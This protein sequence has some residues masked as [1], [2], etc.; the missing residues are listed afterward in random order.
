[1]IEQ[2]VDLE[3][4]I[5]NND[6]DRIEKWMKEQKTGMPLDSVIRRLV[7][8]RVLYGEDRA[9]QIVTSLSQ[10][11]NS[12]HVLSWDQLEQWDLNKLVLVARTINEKV[13]PQFGMI[14]AIEGCGQDECFV[15]QIGQA[16][17]K[18]QRY[19]PGSKEVK[20]IIQYLTE[21]IQNEQLALVNTPNDV[22]FESRVNI[23][24][25][26]SGAGIATKIINALVADFRFV[27]YNQTWLLREWVIPIEKS[28]IRRIHK[29]IVQSGRFYR[30]YASLCGLIW[31]DAPQFGELSI[32]YH[33]RDWADYFQNENEGWQAIKPPPP[34]WNNAK[35]SCYVFNPVDFQIILK[36]GDRLNKSKAD[37]LVTL[38]YYAD[39]VDPID[40]DS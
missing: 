12:A 29:E 2:S 28:V 25:L 34:T 26:N 11:A 20:Q 32:W 31:S 15:I 13:T 17:I 19:K 40:I 38:G 23:Y 4:Q 33:L 9:G 24:I 22:D 16:F 3:F 27:Q 35:G 8:G 39:V 1:M 7:R 30:D 21:A 6:L 36:P 10:Y 18:Y 5:T 14:S 37:L